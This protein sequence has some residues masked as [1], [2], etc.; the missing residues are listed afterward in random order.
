M[1]SAFHLK[2]LAEVRFRALAETTREDRKAH[3]AR[4]RAY[5]A[6][7]SKNAPSGGLLCTPISLPA[8]APL[9]GLKTQSLDT[10][11]LE[12]PHTPRRGRRTEQ[13][14]GHCR[15][16]RKSGGENAERT[17]GA[18]TEHHRA[19]RPTFSKLPP[20]K[21]LGERTREIC[22]QRR[23]ISFQNNFTIFLFKKAS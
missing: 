6:P 22:F 9:Y 4:K 12:P 8:P 10:G 16:P 17:R 19:Q 3:S 14:C 13:A 15:R 5:L 11:L 21:P 18:I 7:A 2:N 1:E 20:K 23:R